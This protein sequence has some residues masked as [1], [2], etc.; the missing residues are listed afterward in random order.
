MVRSVTTLLIYRLG[1]EGK[2]SLLLYLLLLPGSVPIDKFSQTEI[3]LIV[4]ISQSPSRG[5]QINSTPVLYV[6]WLTVL[7]D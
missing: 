2:T 4:K 3:A 1:R 7:S 5:K 6:C